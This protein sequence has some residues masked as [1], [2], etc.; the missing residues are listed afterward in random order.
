MDHVETPVSDAFCTQLVRDSP[1]VKRNIPK[2]KKIL[3][4][5]RENPQPLPSRQTFSATRL[6]QGFRF[7]V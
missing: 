1:V 5:L 7:R 4:S 3:N 2:I 6:N